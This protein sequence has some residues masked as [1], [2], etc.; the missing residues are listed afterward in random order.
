LKA[1][2]IDNDTVKIV[3]SP[4]YNYNFRKTDGYFERWGQKKEDDPDFS[5]LGPEILDLEI[6]AGAD[7][8]GNCSFC[9]KA[10]GAQGNTDTVNMTLEQFQTILDKMPRV[11]TQIAFGICNVGTNPDFFAMMEHARSKGIIPNYTCHGLDV[12]DAVAERTASLCGAVAVSIV[13]KDRSYEAVQRFVSKGMKQVN[14]H[15]MLSEETLDKAMKTVDD[16]VEDPRLEGMNAIVFL[17][18]KPKG[19]HPDAFH[20]IQSPGAYTKLVDYCEER[21]VR[22]G[23]DSC[24]A[25]LFF[26]AIEGNEKRMPLAVMA[27]PCEAFG[28]FSSYINVHGVYYPCSF[29]E[30]EDGWESGLDVLNCENFLKEIWFNE[31]LNGWRK[32]ILESSKGCD[33]HFSGMCRSCPVFDVTACK[34]E[35]VG[36]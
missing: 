28:M 7:C 30:G 34:A 27:E 17:Q 23:F 16:M 32:K 20:C 31:K 25:P 8:L 13:R 4:V 11:L 3:R 12:D 29:C 19:R 6:S 24:S 5:P 33:C 35:A 14:I 18:Y 1:A 2:L 26:K 15:F 21:G 10:N 22:Y 36:V 9:Y